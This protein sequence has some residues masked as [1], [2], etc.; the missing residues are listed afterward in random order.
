MNF[1][2]LEIYLYNKTLRKQDRDQLS[3][4]VTVSNDYHQSR[5]QIQILQDLI[6]TLAKKIDSDYTNV[7]IKA[8][9]VCIC[10]RLAP[11]MPA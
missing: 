7:G 2:K 4:L 10:T 11:N 6:S 3:S 8:S 5:I 1:K 9:S